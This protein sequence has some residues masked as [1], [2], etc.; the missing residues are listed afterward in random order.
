MDTSELI[1]R[2]LRKD[3]GAWDMF[4]R[5]YRPLVVRGV[6]YKLSRMNMP[7]CGAMCDD[8]VQD[9]FICIWE[10]DRL[11]EVRTVE[12]LRGWLAIL[13]IN[14]VANH[15]VTKE[16]RKSRKT[17]SLNAPISEDDPSL[18][19]ETAVPS[20]Q[21]NT[22]NMLAANELGGILEREISK[23]DHRYQLAVK[24]RLYHGK[25]IKDVAGIM[26]IPEGTAAIL[27]KR[28]MDKLRLKLEYILNG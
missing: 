24:L 20:V 6:K 7:P 21:L 4:V 5:R 19:L 16:F 27:L 1:K 28:A 3:P 25:R 12:T 22:E 13:S 26:N 23:L 15:C 9:I 14:A 2:C 10:K 18:T 8:I 11:R 17:L